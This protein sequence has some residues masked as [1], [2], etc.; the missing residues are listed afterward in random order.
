M[1]AKRRGWRNGCRLSSSAQ[2]VNRLRSCHRQKRLGVFFAPDGR[3]VGFYT[4]SELK[5]IRI[6]EPNATTLYRRIS[7][8]RARR[9]L[10][11]NDRL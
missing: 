1:C 9:G 6:G 7:G 2:R 10:A 8:E 11:M 5:R 4:R 3:S